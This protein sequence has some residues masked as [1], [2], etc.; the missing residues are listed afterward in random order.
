MRPS[1]VRA[2]RAGWFAA[3]AVGAAAAVASAQ[4]VEP[5]VITGSGRTFHG[6]WRAELRLFRDSWSPGQSIRYE[7]ALR[8]ADTHM[9]GLAD[10]GIKADRLCVLITAERTFDADGWLRLASDERMSTLLTP[11]GLAIEG[12]VQGA[13][14]TRYGYAF[15]SPLDDLLT[16]PVSQLAAG[17]EPGSVVAQFAGFTTLPAD[18][19]PGLYR[20]RLDFGVMAGT[21][22]YNI[23]GFTFASRPFSSSEAGTSTYYYTSIIPAHGTHVSGRVVDAATIQPRF[24][25]LLLATYGSNGYR[26]VVADEDRKRFAT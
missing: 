1:V 8:L 4:S 6:D 16:F 22:T 17:E 19:P 3:L 24:P 21:R 25:W 2:R 12:G 10:K 5:R 23:N 7:V 26:G 14:T 18:L 15:K 13:V 11:A 9:A 20:L